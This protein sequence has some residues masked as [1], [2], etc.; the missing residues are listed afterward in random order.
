MTVINTNIAASVTANAMKSNARAMENTMERLATGSRVNSASDDAA[1]LAIGSKMTS[2][3][4]GLEQAVRNANDAVSLLQTADGASIEISDMLQ[5]MR[6]LA[7]QSRNDTNDTDDISNLN[8][9]FAALATEIDRIADTTEFNGLKVLQGNLTSASSQAD[10]LDFVV[11]KD[12]SDKL[13]VE[14]S[15]F[16]L[17][18]GASRV[19]EVLGSEDL[20]RT[21]GSGTS[22][23]HDDLDSGGYIYVSDGSETIS[24][25]LQ[26]VKVANN[27]TTITADNVTGAQVLK[28][29]TT[30]SSASTTFKFEFAENSGNNGFIITEKAGM[31]GTQT[32]TATWTSTATSAATITIASGQQATA[33][34]VM[35]TGDLSNW[36]D[37]GSAVG[38]NVNGDDTIS[39]LD[40]A[41]KGVAQARADF[42]ASINTLEHSID[43]LNV[44][45]QNTSAARSAVMDADYATETTELARTQILAQAAT[46]MLSQANQQAQSVLALLK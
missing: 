11:G 43:N 20:S 19:D 18:N 10:R 37:T 22:A 13:T 21:G 23:L 12:A 45:V 24:I 17:A 36:K 32:G 5:R 41:I 38:Y 29:L 25:N 30:A 40:T 3:I 34:G 42:G 33:A 39:R 16:N 46:A 6:E 27:S 31:G 9:E 15:D 28:A 35:G 7:V 8:K 1:G 44:A 4:R 2:Q 26:D 14:F